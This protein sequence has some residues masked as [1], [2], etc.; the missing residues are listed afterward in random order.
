MRCMV[1]PNARASANPQLLPNNCKGAVVK[2]A[3]HTVCGKAGFVTCCITKASGTKC[4]TK[5]DSMYCTDA[6]RT[7]LA[8]IGVDPGLVALERQNVLRLD[9]GA[10]LREAEDVAGLELR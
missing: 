9:V 1:M 10:V 5:K 3:A 2:C 6:G 8:Q 7:E 4:K